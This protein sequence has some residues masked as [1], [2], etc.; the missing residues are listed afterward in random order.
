MQEKFKLLVVDDNGMTREVMNQGL[1]RMEEIQVVG[2][3][4]NGQEALE[5]IRKYQ[6]DIMVLDLI[7]PI[8]DGV[9]VLEQ[10]H[11]MP[12]KHPDVLV[13]SAMGSEDVVNEVMRFGVRYFMVKPFEIDQICRRIRDIIDQNHSGKSGGYTLG[14]QNHPR[15]VDEEIT[16]VFLTIGIPAHI[17]GYQY[18]REAVKMV[19]ERKQL[20]GSITKELYPGIAERF[21]TSASK[22]ERA[23]RHAI[24]VAWTKGR[25]ENIN[26]IFG[27]N[28]YTLHDKPTNGEFIALLA[29]KMSMEHTA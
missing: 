17:K 24:D 21:D 18:L 20:I 26:R 7:M 15:S 22:V 13:L 29:D 1:G 19:M 6:P 12:G 9:G 5:M 27:Y 10:M 11:K 3:A 25:I 23:I 16:S 2:L 14:N 28:I 8:L 4:A